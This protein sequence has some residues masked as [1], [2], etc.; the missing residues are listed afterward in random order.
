V[1]YDQ[2]RLRFGDRRGG[3][4]RRQ[5][6]W[7][8]R[9]EVPRVPPSADV[10]RAER[11][12]VRAMVQD[13]DLVESVA[14]RWPPSDFHT[15]AFRELFERLLAEPHRPLDEAT[16]DFPPDAV[17]LID[18]ALGEP[19]PSPETTVAGRLLQLQT[20]ALDEEKASILRQ[21]AASDPPPTDDV[22]TRLMQR[23]QELQ[24]ERAALS[25]SYARVG[26]PLAPPPD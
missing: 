4:G 3:R 20:R 14:E 5:D 15:P 13:R 7:A 17:A 23:M 2:Y 25:T 21:L 22:K 10:R 19:D 1:P 12:L 18:H 9:R 11:D 6:E 26:A 16:R 24:R 8:S